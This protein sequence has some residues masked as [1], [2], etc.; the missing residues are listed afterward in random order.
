MSQE[1]EEVS[2]ETKGA[3]VIF[4]KTLTGKTITLDVEESDTVSNVKAKIQDVEG[5]PPDQQRLIFAGKQLEDGRTLSE[6][7]VSYEHTLHLVLRLRGMISN[8]SEFDE[9]DPLTWYL[10]KGDVDDKGTVKISETL[11]KQ[12]RKKLGGA[13]CSTLRLQYTGEHFLNNN[14]R[15]KLIGIANYVHSI[16]EMEGK[17][18]KLL[19]DIKI[20]IPPGVL[21]T[22]VESEAA[23]DELKNHHVDPSDTKFVLRRTTQTRGCLPWHVDGCYSKCVVQYTLN[24]DKLYKGGRLCYYTDDIGLLVPRRPAGTLTVHRKEM[25]AVSR[26]LS[27]VRYSLFVVDMSNGLGGYSENITTISKEKLELLPNFPN[28]EK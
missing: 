16:Q 14:Q 28:K 18:D 25:H 3:K 9:S 7:E 4:I 1:E 22:I 17:S 23:E 24:D 26:C 6:C 12:R 19:Q 15:R 10:M 5:I 27:G 8:F 13:A 11:L 21:N 2:K 20:I